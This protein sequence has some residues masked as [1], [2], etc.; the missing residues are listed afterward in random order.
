MAKFTDGNRNE[1]IV[2]VDVPTIER[3]QQ[4]LD[5]FRVDQI[6]DDDMKGLLAL[7]ADPVKLVRLLW[8]V[9]EEQAEKAKVSPE[10][11]GRALHGDALEDALTALQEAV[12]DFTPRRRRAV[13]KALA[14]KSVDVADKT[15]ALA[16]TEVAAIDPEKV[17]EEMKAR[18]RTRSGSATNSPASSESTPAPAG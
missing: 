6:F 10:Q 16:L 9:V 2:F 1:W 12:A 14:A 17:I 11:F 7:V 3:V 5:G 13:L 15:A 4:R 8:I 18:G